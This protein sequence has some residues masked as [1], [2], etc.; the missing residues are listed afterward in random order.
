MMSHSRIFSNLICVFM[1]KIH[2]FE[3]FKIC[4]LFLFTYVVLCKFC[5]IIILTVI[6]KALFYQFLNDKIIII[7]NE[8]FIFL[9]VKIFPFKNIVNP[10]SFKDSTTAECTYSLSIHSSILELPIVICDS[11]QI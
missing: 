5:N 6:G 9:M 1:G 2:R 10:F 3:F 7:L 4:K 11:I 8:F